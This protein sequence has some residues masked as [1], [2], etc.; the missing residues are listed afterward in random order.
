LAIIIALFGFFQMA[1]GILVSRQMKEQELLLFIG[2]LKL[3]HNSQEKARK[4]ASAAAE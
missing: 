4:A 2:R 3:R 1:P